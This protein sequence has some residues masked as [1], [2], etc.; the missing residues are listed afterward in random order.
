MVTKAKQDSRGLSAENTVEWN[1]DLLRQ[2]GLACRFCFQ[3]RT[4]MKRQTARN[5]ALKSWMRSNEPS[6]A[7]VKV[8]GNASE[9]Q[10]QLEKRH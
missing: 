7:V 4:L 9:M 10:R 3:E 1:V 6:I 2:D 8:V 5:C